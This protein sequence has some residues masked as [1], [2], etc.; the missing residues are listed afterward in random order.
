MPSA[1][2]SP[3]H[4]T[5]AVA[6]RAPVAA[7]VA[8]A[9]LA[10]TSLTGCGGTDG[11]SGTLRTTEV[12]GTDGVPMTG[13]W[14]AVL[15]ADQLADFLTQ[16]GIDVPGA[17]G[18]AFVEGRVRHEAV[19]ET[20]GT[21]LAVDDDGRFSTTVTGPRRLCVLRELPQVDLVRGCVEVDLPD[22]GNLDLTLGDDGLR[23]T[24]RD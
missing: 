19:S 11:L 23:A 22:D 3:R 10:L 13:G 17:D 8:V 20:G 18:L 7:L 4:P 6:A 14:V 1:A 24:L 21:L 9:A 16:S 12:K 5:A 15:T 2:G